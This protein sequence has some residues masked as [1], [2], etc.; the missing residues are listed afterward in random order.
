M[1]EADTETTDAT[2]KETKRSISLSVATLTWSAVTAALLVALVVMGVLLA[3][4]RHEV[5]AQ[6]QAQDRAQRA[7]DVASSYAVGAATVDYQQFD[8]WV[9]KLKAGTT[10]K[11]ANK[12]DATAPKL[13][14]ILLPLR[15]KSTA[16]PISAI[17]MSEDNGTYKVNVFLNVNSSNAQSPDGTST[18]VTY[19]VAVDTKDNWKVADVGGLDG[20]LPGK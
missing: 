3:G 16:T 12:F 20:A 15:W 10:D 18:T 11:L 8:Q 9:G 7:K 17:V 1:A 4:A 13:Q 5:A 2:T 14:Q 6:K 19:N